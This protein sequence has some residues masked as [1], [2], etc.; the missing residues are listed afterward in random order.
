LDWS[1]DMPPKLPIPKRLQGVHPG[2]NEGESGG[3]NLAPPNGSGSANL[4]PPKNSSKGVK[5]S[6]RRAS[7]PTAVLPVDNAEQIVAAIKARPAKVTKRIDGLWRQGWSE[8][9]LGIAPGLTKKDRGQLTMVHARIADGDRFLVWS[10]QNWR[11]LIAE[12]FAW[13]D[14]RSPPD[15]PQPGFL[16]AHVL[17]FAEA[18]A[19]ESQAHARGEL[20]GDERLFDELTATGL[21]PEAAWIE[22]GRRKA[23][24]EENQRL[25]AQR[26]DLHRQ[27]RALERE[28]A[29]LRRTPT[30]PRAPEPPVVIDHGTNPFDNGGGS[31]PTQFGDFDDDA[32]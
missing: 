28:R 18:F 29:T 30:A 6:S 16:L 22:I 25:A 15:R 26:D 13:M 7:A 10:I 32:Q 11:R 4:A 20:T 24:G 14:Q 5:A 21:A 9:Q 2:A 12:R 17:I 1:M 8:G 23:V 3:V 31:V 19:E 27:F